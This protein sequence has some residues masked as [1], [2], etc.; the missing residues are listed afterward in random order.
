LTK[1]ILIDDHGIIR[2]A[3]KA[4]LGKIEG[5]E[6]IAE[7]G[8]GEEAVH[9]AR[10]L[11]PDLIVMDI[12]MPGIGG[13]EAFMR[14]SSRKHSP[15]ILI[16]SSYTNDIVPTRLI[17]LGVAGYL[18]KEASSFSELLTTAVKEI[19]AG[20]RYIEPAILDKLSV[21]KVTGAINISHLKALQQDPLF[22]DFNDRELQVF[23]MVAKGM[24]AKEISQK[25]YITRK[26]ANAHRN[27]IHKK[28]ELDS[29]VDI[30]RLAVDKG[31]ID[32]DVDWH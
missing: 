9:L 21:G 26:T 3:I 23:V 24:S 18:T 22:H 1:I 17:Q 31:L 8:T 12:S 11:L 15:K 32:P 20:G 2:I 6:V 4:I 7:A 19:I 14:I 27:S 10:T 25:L 30:A 29:D 16:V 13:M 28:L 5:V